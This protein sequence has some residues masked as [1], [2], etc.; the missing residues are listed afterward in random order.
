MITTL[1]V[2]VSVMSFGNP[3]GLYARSRC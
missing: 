1:A 2:A 3:V